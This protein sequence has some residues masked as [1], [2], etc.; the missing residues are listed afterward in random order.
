Y[1]EIADEGAR[2]SVLAAVRRSLEGELAITAEVANPFGYAR[3]YVQ[4]KTGQ[5]RASF[6]FPHDSD[7]APWWQG[8]NARLASLAT[9]A[10]LAAQVFRQDAPFA[11]RLRAYAAHQLDWILGLNPFDSSMIHG[12]GRNNPEQMFFDSWEFTNVPGGISNGIT[13]GFRDE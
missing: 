9:A 5:R 3:Q 4:S 7:T 13:A 10:N 1:A 8:E 2:Q 6:F 12:I 11:G